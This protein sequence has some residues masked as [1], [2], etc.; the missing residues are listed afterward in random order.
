MTNEN[1]SNEGKIL[2]EE[3]KERIAGLEKERENFVIEANKEIAAYNGAI[4]ELNRLIDPK[5]DKAKSPETVV[6][7]K[8]TEPEKAPL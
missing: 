3:I 5:V 6:E 2:V 1:K 4:M 7:N 8:P